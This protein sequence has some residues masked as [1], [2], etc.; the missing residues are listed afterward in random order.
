MAGGQGNRSAMSERAWWYFMTMCSQVG[1]NNYMGA[2]V[3]YAQYFKWP[4]IAD[5]SHNFATMILAELGVPARYALCRLF[6]YWCGRFISRHSPESAIALAFVIA[7]ILYA[8]VNTVMVFSLSRG[9]AL[10]LA[11][12]DQRNWQF[13]WQ[14][15]LNKS[16]VCCHAGFSDAI[17]LLYLAIFSSHYLIIIALSSTPII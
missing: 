2:S 5:H 16:H 11:L 1:W 4:E 12:I 7:S 9:F 13:V 17:R 10:F 3:D 6:G 15:K 14:S 8:S